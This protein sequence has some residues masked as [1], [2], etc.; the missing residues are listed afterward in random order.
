VSKKI[1]LV[2]IVGR[3]NVGKSTLFNTICAK[4][5]A[6]VRDEP[7]V[8]RDRTY[9]HVERLRTP[10]RLVD[11]GGLVGEE[12]NPFESEVRAQARLAIEEADLILCVFDA[13]VGVHPYDRDVVNIL[14]ESSKPVIWV[15]NKAEKKESQENASEFYSLGIDHFLV[16]SAAHR[17]GTR[18]LFQLLETELEQI[19]LNSVEEPELEGENEILKLAIVGKPNVGK[20]TLVN[21]LAGE[22]R[23]ITSEISG[24]THDAVDVR[25]KREGREY[26]IVDT[27]GLRRKA[28]VEDSSLEKESQSKSLRALAR[29]DVG[30]FM[31]DGENQELTDQDKKIVSL[32]HRRGIP[33]VIVVN[34]WDLVEKDHRTAKKV[35]EFIQEQL[36][37][38]KYAPVLFISAQTG[39][40]S[41]KVLDHARKVYEQSRFRIPTSE[42]NRILQRAFETKAPPMHRGQAVKMYFATQVGITP[43]TIVV[44]VNYPKN[45]P[46][47]YERFLKNSLRKDY[48]FEGSN[49]KIVVRKRVNKDERLAS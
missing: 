3:A 41:P 39:K 7:G 29:C 44:F 20:S 2:A 47:T 49:I 24:T 5:I 37:F 38:C 33:L 10:F 6:L 42:L 9:Q 11:T 12:D 46:E 31:V 35:K 15:V 22:Q 40:G 45:I 32:I 43:P 18:D 17:V 14:R 1:P 48:P 16:I 21:R 34:K 28:R 25:I 8:T 19:A 30:V 13:L 26:L 27:P 36:H 4:N 23:V